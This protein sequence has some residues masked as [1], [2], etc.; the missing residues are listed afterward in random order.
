MGKL[1]QLLIASSISLTGITAASATSLTGGGMRV[2]PHQAVLEQAQY[3]S[4]SCAVWRRECADLYGW[5][6]Q[7]WQVCMGQPGAIRACSGG[8][9]DGDRG[10][11]SCAVWRRECADLYGWQTRRWHVCMGQ[12]GAIRACRGGY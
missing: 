4:R 11:R 2:T 12:P 10:S 6:T 3:G 9:D 8:Y 1:H 7:R 5:R